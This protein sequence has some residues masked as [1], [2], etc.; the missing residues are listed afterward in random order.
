M[1]RHTLKQ[2][3]RREF[4][5]AIHSLQKNVPSEEMIQTPVKIMMK[6]IQEL[7]C[8]ETKSVLRDTDDGLRK[9]SWEAV[10]Q[11]MALKASTVLHFYRQLFRGA[12]KPLICFAISMIIKWRSPK[13]CLIQRVISTLLYGNSVNKKVHH[14]S[15]Y[16]SCCYYTY[17]FIDIQLFATID[18][19]PLL[20]W[21]DS[22]NE[23]LD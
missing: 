11:E 8:M 21:N 19:V 16:F 20:Q 10:W 9:F 2:V 5:S 7:C 12:S 13:M 6:E 14:R 17:A 3:Y 1:R 4:S 22:T 23:T 15:I 18:G